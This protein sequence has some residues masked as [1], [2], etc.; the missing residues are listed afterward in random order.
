M[1][2]ASFMEADMGAKAEQRLRKA[3]VSVLSQ[4]ASGKS[5]SQVVK[6]VVERERVNPEEV[7][8]QI[9]ALM[10]SGHVVLGADLNLIIKETPLLRKTG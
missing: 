4:S 2:D 9:R 10:E 3:V 1:Y 7:R 6:D 5:A 8:R